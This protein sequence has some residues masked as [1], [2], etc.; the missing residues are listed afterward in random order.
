MLFKRKKGGDFLD[1]VI[2]TFLSQSYQLHNVARLS[3][4]ESLGLP[5]SGKSVL[6]FGAG[7]GDH[8]LYYLIKNCRVTATDSRPELV[9]FIKK[10]LGITTM[11]IDV[12][13]DIEDIK[14]LPHFDIIHCY[15]LL[16]HVPNPEEFI[17]SIKGK[18]DLLLL[19]TCVSH[20]FREN[21]PYVVRED[22]S[23]PTQASSGLGCRPTRGW[24]FERLKKVFPYVYLPVSQPNHEEFPKDWSSPLEDRSKLIR[25]IFIGS[26][27]PVKNDSLTSQLIKKYV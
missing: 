23:N 21:D 4:L 20:D 14:V 24:I 10:R 6:E 16:Y 12:K 19:E 9:G 22:S 26:T 18:S 7:V 15:G 3:H 27:A 11:K 2:K 8:S 13:R 17:F 1:G 25:A 5:L